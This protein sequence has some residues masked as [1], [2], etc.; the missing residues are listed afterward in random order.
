MYFK[1]LKFF[2]LCNIILTF[3]FKLEAIEQIMHQ[4]EGESIKNEM[5]LALNII[6]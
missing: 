2:Q 4:F 3:F 1:I 5:I 6:I